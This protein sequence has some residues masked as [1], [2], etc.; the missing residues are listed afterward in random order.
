MEKDIH[1]PKNNKAKIPFFTSTIK[2][3]TISS[4]IIFIIIL[5]LCG[6]MKKEHI[7]EIQ[8]IVVLAIGLILLASFISF[9]PEDLSWYTS[10][11]NIPAKNLI[12]VV[13][14]YIAG[15]FFFLLGYSSY[16]L[17]AFFLFWSWNKFSSRDLEF[18]WTKIA[19]S[20]VLF[21]V[22]SS[23]FS[24]TGSQMATF[25]FERGGNI[26][27]M[28]ADF[29]VKYLGWAGAYI[30]LL[31]LGALTLVVTGEF[32]VFCCGGGGVW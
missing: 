7:N 13:G 8:G 20:L 19:S 14:A 18:T 17:V 28:S 9:V 27:F 11:P 4:S 12:R 6:L 25:R 30:I 5:I 1:L 15:I 32:L 2:R 10:S 31:T 24:M 26:G 23:V 3:Y 21:G 22:V 29:L 16:F